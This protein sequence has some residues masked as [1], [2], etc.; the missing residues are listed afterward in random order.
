MRLSK[1]MSRILRHH[2]PASM[3][4]SGWVALPDLQGVLGGNVTV[5]RIR[6]VTTNDAKGR[7]QVRLPACS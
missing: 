2:P 6:Q 5:E 4:A 7:F 1:N 3:D